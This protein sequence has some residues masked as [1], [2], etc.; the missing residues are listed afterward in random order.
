MMEYRDATPQRLEVDTPEG[1]LV[2]QFPPGQVV[3]DGCWPVAYQPPLDPEPYI[4]LDG[5]QVSHERADAVV[6]EILRSRK[7]R[8][9]CGE[10]SESLG[11]RP[12]G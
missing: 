6:Q 1:K 12:G 5:V 7:D 10:V 8:K 4:T 3:Y 11:R 2:M 9:L